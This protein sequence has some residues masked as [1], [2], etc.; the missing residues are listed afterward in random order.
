M[1]E[2]P[3]RD[4]GDGGREV[5]V[6]A[7]CGCGVTHPCEASFL[8]CPKC[9]DAGITCGDKPGWFPTLAMYRSKVR[10]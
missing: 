2:L 9:R 10:P 4:C 6:F 8:V 3:W 7:I 1:N 5:A